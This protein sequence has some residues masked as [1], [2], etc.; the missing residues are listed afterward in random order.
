MSANTQT[1]LLTPFDKFLVPYWGFF[2]FLCI[3]DLAHLSCHPLLTIF[4]H[5][6]S[7]ILNSPHY[8]DPEKA[9]VM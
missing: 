4:T 2:G 8:G 7:P 3:W 5:F 9:G 1:L 6:P